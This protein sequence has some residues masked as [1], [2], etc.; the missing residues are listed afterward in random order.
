MAFV[1]EA[2]L[3]PARARYG[4]PRVLR[5]VQPVDRAELDLV[6][7]SGRRHDRRHDVTFFVF[8]GE[9]LAL[10]RK[11]HFLPGVWRPPSGGLRPGES[12]E[13]GVAREALE[14]LGA[15]IAL[16]R[17]LVR[18]EARFRHG[19]EWIDWRT[20]V[21]S[22]ATDADELLPT[23]TVEIAAARWGTAEELAGPIRSAA[24]ATGRGLWRYRVALH[25]AAIAA[26]GRP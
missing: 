24:L 14:E 20:H 25:D 5:L 16:E 19:N 13:E 22:A 11:P 9:R 17:Y 15:E 7:A 4:E 18:A 3:G 21:F 2:V 10:I 23:D 12:L 26:L 6:V 8:N 1:D